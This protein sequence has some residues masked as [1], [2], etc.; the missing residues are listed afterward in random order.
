[1]HAFS[2]ATVFNQG[3]LSQT[4]IISGARV[5][6]PLVRIDKENRLNQDASFHPDGYLD[7]GIPSDWRFLLD[8][9]D[10]LGPEDLFDL[11]ISDLSWDDDDPD[12]ML[13]AYAKTHEA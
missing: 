11:K 1:M 12:W 8:S 3:R 6:F 9:E 13:D 2:E 10:T 7:L 5:L 4:E